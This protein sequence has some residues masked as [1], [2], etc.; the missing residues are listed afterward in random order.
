MERW[1]QSDN[2]DC[3]RAGRYSNSVFVK[4]NFQA[5]C[6]NQRHNGYA[7][8]GTLIGD[9]N[10]KAI[11]DTL[12]KNLSKKASLSGVKWE[13]VFHDGLNQYGL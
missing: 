10:N 13:V 7:Y 12:L 2:W 9:M 8:I 4:I 1:Y 11:D 6:L 5:F 3:Q